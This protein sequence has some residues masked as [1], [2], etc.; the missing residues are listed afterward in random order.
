M[1]APSTTVTMA[2]SSHAKSALLLALASLV[3]LK[4]GAL[5]VC[6]GG[7]CHAPVLDVELL[8]RL[9][10]WRT[11]SLDVFFQV[12]TWTGSLYV[13][14]PLAL[15]LAALDTRT[16]QGY[17]RWFVPLALVSHWPVVHAT[18]LLIAR[19]RPNLY[20]ALIQ[21]P[22]DHSFPSAHAAQITAFA[23]AY[24]L[25]P[26]Q[27]TSPMLAMVLLV[28]V[29]TVTLS[30]LYLQVHYPSDVLF[31]TGAAVLWVL[32]LRSAGRDCPAAV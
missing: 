20:E 26:G 12:I 11:P 22:T 10:A 24:L 13:L 4:L 21:L 15:V 16:A 27:H 18:K 23:C 14:L 29:V 8:S 25:R 32:A 1:F 9:H 28:A 2:A 31:A 6:P 17:R 30:R 5:K 19:P 7:R 3:V